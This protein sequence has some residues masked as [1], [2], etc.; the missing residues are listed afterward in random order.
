MELV[1]PTRD[2]TILIIAISYLYKYQVKLTVALV[3]PAT[4]EKLVHLRRRPGCEEE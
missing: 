1:I 4:I 2:T 3:S